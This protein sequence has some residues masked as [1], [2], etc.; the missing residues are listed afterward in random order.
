MYISKYTELQC[1][2]ENKKIVT[3]ILFEYFYNPKNHLNFYGYLLLGSFI[4]TK[5]NWSES[6]KGSKYW[7]TELL[8]H[9][10]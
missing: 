9:M 10:K 7:S 2:K 6:R 5:F 3:E 4:Q 8:K 1:V